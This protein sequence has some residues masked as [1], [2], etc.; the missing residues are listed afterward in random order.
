MIMAATAEPTVPNPARPTLSGSAMKEIR[1][2]IQRS[3]AL[4][5]RHHVV[6]LFRSAFKKAANIAGRLTNALLVLD[7]RNAHEALAAL[8][9]AGARRHRDLSFFD[10]ELRKL[11]TAKHLEQL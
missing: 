10:Q 2:K 8:A 5:K 6:Q 7:E 9:E 11:D 1:E 4:G 3:A